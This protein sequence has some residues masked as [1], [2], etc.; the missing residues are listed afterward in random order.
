MA[1]IRICV[2]GLGEAGGAIAGDLAGHPEAEVHGYDPVAAGTPSGVVR[3][4]EAGDAA[5]GAELVLAVTASADATTALVQTLDTLPDRA[6]YADLSTSAPKL[7][8]RLAGL[9]EAAGLRFVDVALMQPVPG[10]GLSTPALA[11]GPAADDFAALLRPLG[12]PVEAVGDEPG[13]AAACKLLRSVLMKGL[14]A[15]LIESLRAAEAAGL[16]QETWQNLVEQ[17][18]AVDE[19]L[20]RRL[21]VGTGQHARRRLHEMEAATELLHELGVDPVMT[22][23]T[24]V[25]LRRLTDDPDDLPTLPLPPPG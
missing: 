10:G 6:I 19:G 15:V 7:K 8:Q 25:S 16:S 2:L 1:T 5:A 23:S 12:M 21:V 4:G 20:V 17:L 22:R 14:A 9:A 3:H 18:G 11:S 13:K 24:V